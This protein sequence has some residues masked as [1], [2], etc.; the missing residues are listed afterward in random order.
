MEELAGFGAT[1][2]TCSRNE[3]ELN[4]CLKDWEEKGFLVTGSV[5][6]VS[7]PAQR[8]KLMVKVSSTFKGRLN[9]LVI[10]STSFYFILFYLSLI[11]VD[12][13]IDGN[14]KRETKFFQINTQLSTGINKHTNEKTNFYVIQSTMPMSTPERPF[15]NH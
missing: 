14:L 10:N 15:F 6:D 12:L 2:H 5:C 7:S 3:G 9:I 8:E 13:I 4:G 11:F 1:V